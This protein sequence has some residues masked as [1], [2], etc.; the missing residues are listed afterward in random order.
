M[1]RTVWGLVGVGACVVAHAQSVDWR[2]VDTRDPDAGA[3]FF[4]A[5]KD[6][7]YWFAVRTLDTK[8]RL[9]PSDEKDVEPN[10]RVIVDTTVPAMNQAA[11]SAL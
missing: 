2:K 8:T 11:I 4:R 3:F 6:G 10:M 5:P 1:K 9:I 7:E